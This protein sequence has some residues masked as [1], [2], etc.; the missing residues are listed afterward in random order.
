MRHPP[1]SELPHY[2]RLTGHR[3]LCGPLSIYPHP[4][5]AR[6]KWQI[7]QFKLELLTRLVIYERDS[8]VRIGFGHYSPNV[9]VR[10][11]LYGGQARCIT[12][13]WRQARQNHCG[14]TVQTARARAR[15]RAM[16]PTLLGLLLFSAA[17]LKE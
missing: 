17:A 1:L 7:D 9:A 6:G 13:L 5:T 14:V 11:P 8:V 15:E 12:S 2:G 3:E 16:I 10:S 4:I